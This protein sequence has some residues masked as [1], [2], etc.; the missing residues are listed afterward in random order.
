MKFR[1]HE[2]FFIRKGWLTKG[3]KYVLKYPNL[4][5]NKDEK[6]SEV[7]G[8]GANMVLA[9]RYWLQ[10][11]GLTVERKN[12]KREQVLTDFGTLVYDNDRYFEELGTLHLL[13]YKLCSNKDDVSSWYFFFNEFNLSEFTKEDFI[14]AVQKFVSINGED[15][16]ALRSLSDDFVCILNTYIP[17]YKADM[18]DFSPEN[19]IACPLGEIGLLESVD[20]KKHIYKKKMPPSSLINPW[21]ALAI[22]MDNANG[23]K[24]IPIQAILNGPCNL[25]KIF[26]LDTI[27]LIDVLRSIERI[28]KI[29]IIRTA[30]LDV[31]RLNDILSFEDCVRSFYSSI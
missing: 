24:E 21:V 7:L 18:D 17:K 2:T 10:A 8:I 23:E 15:E 12:G 19:N 9:L 4:F 22:I 3:M 16:V 27:S 31:I 28:N 11:V 1:A 14:E 6:P 13:Q 20:K 30:G 29:K 5:T 26:N 25:G